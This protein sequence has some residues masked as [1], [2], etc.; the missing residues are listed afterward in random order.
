[1]LRD[2][3]RGAIAG[4]VAT[5]LMD[6]VTASM[7]SAQPEDVTAGEAEARPDGRSSA[8]NLVAR[9]EESTGFELDEDM[10]AGVLRAIHYSLGAVPGAL[11]VALRRHVPLIGLGRGLPYGLL[12]FAVNDEWLNTTLGIAEPPEAYPVEARMRGLI[13]HLVLGGATDTVADLLGG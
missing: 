9:F 3:V 1:M 8:E 7:Y 6:Q 12:L 4:S 11:Y 5:W 10:R 2:I 13:G